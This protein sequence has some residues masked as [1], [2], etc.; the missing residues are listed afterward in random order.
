MGY[1]T[2]TLD[3]DE[4]STKAANDDDPGLPFEYKVDN[5]RIILYR[6][7]DAKAM[8]SF[9]LD[10]SNNNGYSSFSGDDVHSPTSPTTRRFTTVAREIAVQ[11]YYIVATINAPAE[12][13][14]ATEVGSYI[15]DFEN[16]VL[17]LQSNDLSKLTGVAGSGY[18]DGDNT[19]NYKFFMSNFKRGLFLYG[20]SHIYPTADQAQ[21]YPFR[22]LMDRAVAKVTVDDSKM[23]SPTG[24]DIQGLAWKADVTN[25]KTYWIRHEAYTANGTMEAQNQTDRTIL[26]ASDPNFSGISGASETILNQH[27]NYIT[28]ADVTNKY[29]WE[30]L[31]EN[32]M[33][34]GEG[35]DVTTRVILKLNFIP[36]GFAPNQGYFYYRGY[37]FDDAQMKAWSLDPS[38]IPDLVEYL[39]LEAAV[40]RLIAQG[41]DF[42]NPEKVSVDGLIYYPN[43]ISYYSIPIRHFADNQLNSDDFGKHGVVRNNYYRIALG[44]ISGP[45]LPEIPVPGEGYLSADIDIQ[46]WYTRDDQPYEY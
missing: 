26:Y 29:T 30:Y 44:E 5:V 39:G 40:R 24:T 41:Y 27:F 11:D 8:Y 10:A 13:N 16:A 45:G 19:D 17:E 32:T 23:T 22:I 28:E 14:A 6:A 20:D 21:T 38:S 34:P 46:N 9:D 2:I 4:L 15:Q 37:A 42:D 1:F 12:V 36:A 33:D 43:G 35:F 31:P 18:T 7:S 25:K 3:S